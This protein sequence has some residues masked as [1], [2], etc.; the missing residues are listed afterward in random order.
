MKERPATNVGS[1]LVTRGRVKPA[2][3]FLVGRTFG[4]VKDLHKAVGMVSTRRRSTRKVTTAST[5]A[6]YTLRLQV[7]AARLKLGEAFGES[8]AS[9]HDASHL[10]HNRDCFNPAH[11]CMESRQKN[12]EREPCRFREEVVLDGRTI[13]SCGHGD[14]VAGSPRCKLRRLVVQ[15]VKVA[16]VT[17]GVA[18]HRRRL[19]RVRAES[20][21]ESLSGALCA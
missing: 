12:L 16:E 21:C 9:D 7:I 13:L 19:A 10:C 15:T 20:N 8:K 6:T 4:A 14:A 18:E 3:R 1:I 2:F 17:G 11:M 5:T